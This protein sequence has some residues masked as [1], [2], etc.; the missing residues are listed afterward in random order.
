MRLREPFDQ[1]RRLGLG[2]SARPLTAQ[3]LVEPALGVILHARDDVGE[4]SEP[5]VSRA[6]HELHD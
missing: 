6:R 3:Q 4:I 5:M 1:R 2:S